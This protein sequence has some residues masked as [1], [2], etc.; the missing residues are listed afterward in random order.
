[1]TGVENTSTV[2]LDGI[3]LMPLIE[4]KMDERTEPIGFWDYVEDGRSVPAAELMAA[5]LQAQQ[6]GK[7][8]PDDA[9]LGLDAGNITKRYPEDTFPG[10]SAWLDWPLKLHR[11]EEETHEVAFELYNLMEDPVEG[12]DLLARES[13][14]V[15][16]MTRQ[17]EAWLLSVTQSLNGE[18]YPANR[19]VSP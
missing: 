7:P 3:S 1:M 2:P 11:M 12:T 18:D 4:G 14:R 13:I 15:E 17:L 5:L 9:E 6:E 16:A 8:Y 19:S 10:H